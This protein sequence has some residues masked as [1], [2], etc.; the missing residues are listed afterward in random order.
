MK[1]ILCRPKV[2]NKPRPP[3]K[4]QYLKR[5]N[6]ISDTERVKGSAGEIDRR[7]KRCCSNVVLCINLR[8]VRSKCV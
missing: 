4:S 6:T 2:S 7:S 8:D 1:T 3:I 5:V